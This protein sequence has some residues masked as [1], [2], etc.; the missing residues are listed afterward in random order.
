MVFLFKMLLKDHTEGNFLSSLQVTL[1]NIKKKLNVFLPCVHSY[2]TLKL[3][4][5]YDLNWHSLL[6]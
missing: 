6:M 3:T 4:F 2:I 1:N 5:G